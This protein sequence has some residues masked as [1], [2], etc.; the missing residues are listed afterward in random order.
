LSTSSARRY[1]VDIVR[2]AALMGICM[3]NVPFMA[4]PVE[5][6]LHAPKEGL[7]RLA[8]MLIEGLFQL[9]FFLLFSFIFG[10]GMAIQQQ[11]ALRKGQSFNQRYF[12][13]I[14]GLLI[15][16]CANA[17]LV[18]SG[19]ILV[20]YSLL[21]ALLWFTRDSSPKKLLKIAAWML[22]LS[23]LCLVVVA[24]AIDAITN[25]PSISLATEYSLGGGYI[26][27]VLAR[28]EAWPSTFLLMLF[29]QGPL[30]F[31]AFA[32]GLA[33]GKSDFF[34]P[35]NAGFKRLQTKVP[36]LLAIA[37][38]LNLL[39]TL[40]L[41]EAIPARYE[42]TVLLSFVGIAIGAPALAAVY[43]WALVILGRSTRLPGLLILAGQNSL[44]TYV[45]QGIIA[46][47]VFA[48]YGMGLFDQLGQFALLGV[49][50]VI[51][52]VSMLTIG[53]YARIF[54][55]GPL[56]PILHRITGA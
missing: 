30:V 8:V 42:L 34:A 27:T 1:E 9:K 31:A 23:M 49:A 14:L 19:D 44:S 20:L 4:L 22:P 12:R 53:L 2:M 17:V 36:L 13:R 28:I 47:G 24:I 38:P 52:V 15:L 37:I 3:V 29:L 16:G 26:E 10:W 32:A 43:L 11:S 48:G 25:D 39:F 56:E 45:L 5:A 50:F 51:A 35:G 18:F 6:L 40:S 41:V 21:G 55:R 54:G 7:D 33:A 46:G